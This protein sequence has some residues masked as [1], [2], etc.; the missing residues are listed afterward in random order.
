MLYA[1][2][3]D[4]EKM[5]YI[6][7][8][9]KEHETLPMAELKAVLRGRVLEEMGNLVLVECAK[10][11]ELENL[12]F[13]HE[14]GRVVF[15]GRPEDFKKYGF[16]PSKKSFKVRIGG[17]PSLTREL[18]RILHEKTKARVDLEK[19]DETF[20]GFMFKKRLVLSRQVFRRHSRGFEERKV[21]YRPYF[22]PTSMHPKYCRAMVNLSGIRNGR[23][24]DPFTGTGGILIESAML[25]NKTHGSDMDEMMV[26]GARQNLAHMGLKA[27]I[28]IADARRLSKYFRVRFDAIVTDP[29]YGRSSS[30]MGDKLQSLYASFLKEALKILKKNARLVVVAPVEVEV[31]R[32]ARG[33]VIEQKHFQRVHKSL[34]RNFFVL[35]KR[36]KPR[37]V[38][39]KND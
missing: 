16:K 1:S 20:I 6:I 27:E 28:K 30:L 26:L 17:N 9:S 11:K 24:L 32:M 25:G 12:A 4:P 19:P 39:E 7:R 31:E 21:R 18:G 5:R 38:K 13:A 37:G 34:C 23:L 35:R 10:L 8:L 14:I 29:P 36:D 22:H 15:D 33:Y 3:A 2:H